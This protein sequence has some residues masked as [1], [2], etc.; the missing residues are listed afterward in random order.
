MLGFQTLI[1]Y[2]VG[3]AYVCLDEA[4][5]IELPSCVNLVTYI[6]RTT[7]ISVSW[8]KRQSVHCTAMLLVTCKLEES[9]I[10]TFEP[11]HRPL[12]I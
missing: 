12:R 4:T 11:R 10:V 1:C 5:V 3:S 6:R 8:L 9:A 2:F 7:T